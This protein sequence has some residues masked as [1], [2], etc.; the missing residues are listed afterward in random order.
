MRH[1]ADFGC[2]FAW[3][4]T[5][6]FWFRE[7]INWINSRLFE[8]ND[9]QI[10]RCRPLSLIVDFS[11]Q[12]QAFP[13]I[14]T[15]R[16]ETKSNLTRPFFWDTARATCSRVGKASRDLPKAHDIGSC[17]LHVFFKYDLHFLFAWHFTYL[18]DVPKGCLYLYM[19]VLPG[20]C[21][22][23]T[24]LSSKRLLYWIMVTVWRLRINRQDKNMSMWV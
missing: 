15:L 4:K 17:L 21:R 18:L 1:A 23:N 10:L 5:C 24:G 6:A 14:C 20:Y 19:S 12:S 11:V 22:W 8:V 13:G 2:A 16:G 9:I 7:W 3:W